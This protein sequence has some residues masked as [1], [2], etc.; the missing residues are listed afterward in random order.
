MSQL[1][2]YHA[3]GLYGYHHLRMRIKGGAIYLYMVRAKKRC[4][5]CKSYKVIQ[6]GYCWRRLRTLPIGRKP[7]YL[8]TSTSPFPL[9]R[10]RELITTSRLSNSGLMD[11][12]T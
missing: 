6:R 9:P 7:V 5:Y 11:T 12:V 1:L 3:L 8:T 4:F 10:S 2:F